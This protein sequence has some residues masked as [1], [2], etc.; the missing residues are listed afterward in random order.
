MRQNTIHQP[1]PRIFPKAKIVVLLHAVALVGVLAFVVGSAKAAGPWHDDDRPFRLTVSFDPDGVDRSDIATAANVDFSSA[2]TAAG[3]GGQ[4]LDLTSI[5]VVEVTAAGSL[6][7]G[8]VPFQFDEGESFDAA[9][10]ATGDLVVLLEGATTSKRH[11]HV[12][13]R[14]TATTGSFTPEDHSGLGRITV[15]PGQTDQGRAVTRVSNAVGDWYYDMEG[16]G[17]TSI[18]DISGADWVDWN[19]AAG[20]AGQFRGLPNLEHPVSTFHPGV[21]N[22]STVVEQSGPLRA[23]FRTTSD[24]GEWVML[25]SFYRRHV[26]AEVI[27]TPDGADYWFQYEGTP[28]GSL[29]AEDK[30][31]QNNGTT[32][33]FDDTWIN[34]LDDIEWAAVADT[35][36][37]RSLYIAHLDD[38]S[39]VDSY[40]DLDDVMTVL[41]F[42]RSGL[43]TTQRLSGPRTFVVGLV[44][45]STSGAISN[46]I[47]ADI[48]P[49][50]TT[51]GS[52]E[53]ISTTTTT[54]ATTTT[55]C[56]D[57]HDNG[58]AIWAE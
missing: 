10:A 34:D 12:Y 11:Y 17:F 6:V 54:A 55:H 18:N 56:G 37:D 15:V 4:T 50:S 8:S 36:K 47:V 5:A 14:S 29:G 44:D 48:T 16:G 32:S 26:I 21:D 58:S 30:I 51:A 9:T 28:G 57:D 3:A 23:V 31:I 33:D 25:W 53:S 43:N 46:P 41:V 2:F 45:G 22:S 38:D 42:G 20:S 1:T 39:E 19:P 35:T 7:D 13:F 49:F 52:G 40:T 27:D 24:D